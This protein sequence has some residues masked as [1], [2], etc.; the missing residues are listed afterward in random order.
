MK[1][2]DSIAAYYAHM[3]K[4]NGIYYHDW[5][6]QEF[7]FNQGHGYYAVKRF[8]RKL[9]EEAEGYNL[10]DLRIMG[11][12][13]SEGSW[14]YQ[15]VWNVGGGTN[16]Y[17]LVSR[18]WG[19]ATS[20]GKDIRDVAFSNYFPATFGINFGIGPA[21]KVA[22]YEHI[23]A[24]SIGVGA[25][26]M[27]PLSKSSVESCP[28]KYEI[29][30]AIRTWENARAANVFSRS[31]KKRLADPAN[32]WQLEQVDKDHWKLYRMVNSVRGSAINLTRDIA[33]GY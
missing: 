30:R 2:Q 24:I 13:L 7:L 23:E 12:T 19:S 17:D 14:H 25:T 15:S 4:I 9:F 20:E 8:H 31:L 32:N 16:M 33:G 22:D 11:A 5:D 6:G 1:L 28:Q 29:F 21:S 26:Y 3:S 10:P 27:L 18:Q